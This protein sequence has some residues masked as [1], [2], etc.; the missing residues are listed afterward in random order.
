MILELQGLEVTLFLNTWGHS[1]VIWFTIVTATI[2]G[3]Y[4][5]CCSSA[6]C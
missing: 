2:L 4:C 3:I 6:S 1:D 5:T